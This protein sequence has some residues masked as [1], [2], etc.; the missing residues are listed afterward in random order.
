MCKIIED[1]QDEREKQTKLTDI[2]NLIK[3]LGLTL[4]QAMNALEIPSEQQ[5]DFRAL[6]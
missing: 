2:R 4:E 5:A 6:L 3:N 1:L